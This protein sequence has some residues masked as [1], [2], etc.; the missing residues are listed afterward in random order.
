MP[1]KLPEEFRAIMND[2]VE[3]PICEGGGTV[4][5]NAD[6]FPPLE[7]V[8]M[9][10]ECPVC[11]GD[12]VTTPLELFDLTMGDTDQLIEYHREHAV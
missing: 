10:I 8:C 6:P 11:V 7:S 1:I 2:D 9:S 3:C 12:G 4:E 5:Y